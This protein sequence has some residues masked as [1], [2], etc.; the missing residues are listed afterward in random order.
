MVETLWSFVN[1]TVPAQWSTGRYSAKW[2]LKPCSSFKL[3]E[4]RHHTFLLFKNLVQTVTIGSFPKAAMSMSR[5]LILAILM[6][7]WIHS[8][9]S[10]GDP[11]LGDSSM[12]AS[13]PDTEL[14]LGGI[15]E[16]SQ[17]RPFATPVDASVSGHSGPHTVMGVESV[18]ERS[19][20]SPPLRSYIDTGNLQAP[21]VRQE[22]LQ[23]FGSLQD[24]LRRHFDMNWEVWPAIHIDPRGRPV[25]YV[26]TVKKRA[27]GAFTL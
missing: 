16:R 21:L 8:A 12:T 10:G 5:L 7:T 2:E 22:Q 15:Y 4:R 6:L 19:G 25:M 17:A 20:G 13:N 24:D 11:P 1:C 3:S 23:M 26:P 9:R 14:S 18:P 27:L